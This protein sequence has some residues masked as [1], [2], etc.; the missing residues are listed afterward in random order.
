MVSSSMVGTGL[1]NREYERST[2]QP[3]HVVEFLGITHVDHE[4]EFRGPWL[5]ALG[6]DVP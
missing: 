4:F 6:W 1:P 3:P 2:Q 5:F